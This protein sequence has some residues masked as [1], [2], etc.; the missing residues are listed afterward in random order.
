ML[1]N[2]NVLIT[3][4]TGSFGQ[5]LVEKLLTG[6]D[7][8]NKIVIYSRDEFK[9]NEMIKT[10]GN[11]PGGKLRFVIGDVRDK[12]SVDKAIKGIDYVFHA[13]AL[14]QIPSCEY[15]PYEAV[16]T[17][18]IGTQNVINSSIG[19][20]VKK[21]MFI[22]TDKAVNPINLYG[23]TKLV[24]EKL[25]IQANISGRKKTRF[26]AVRY[27]NVLASRGS[28]LQLFKYQIEYLKCVTITDKKMT[29]FWWTIDQAVNFVIDNFF[30]MSGGEIFIPNI[31]SSY[32][33]DL[34]RVLI[35]D[36]ENITVKEIGIRSGEKLHESLITKEESKRLYVNDCGYFIKPDE[37]L[38]TFNSGKYS[39][40]SLYDES[41]FNS[42]N[43]IMSDEKL[44][45]LVGK[46]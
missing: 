44:K 3:G 40:K 26:S 22:G 13:A 4:G 5:A 38:F 42:E 29:R 18:I 2:A 35:G 46:I 12:E 17:N 6:S 24:S 34:A 10:F 1:G 15:N 32:V 45:Q 28:V 7:L 25:I 21:V 30:D 43:T 11:F 20:N 39:E 23:A 41:C 31:M 37:S 19:N 36:K 14:K 16:K 8:P 27:G 9:Q 33:L